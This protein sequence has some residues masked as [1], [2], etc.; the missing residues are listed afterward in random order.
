MARQ[1]DARRS[2][3]RRDRKARA[4]E[5]TGQDAGADKAARFALLA[6][7]VLGGAGVAFWHAGRDGGSDAQHPSSS[8]SPG[9]PSAESPDASDSDAPAPRFARSMACRE[10]HEKFY[11]LWAQ[12]HHGRAMQPFTP[13][14]AK[15]DLTPHAEAITVGKHRYRAD[16]SGAEAC[17]H[18]EGPDG[19][20]RYAIKHAM[21]GK[22]VYYFLTPLD[23]GRLQVLPIAYDVR[24]KNWY[25]V[26]ASM[27]RHIT[28]DRAVHWRDPLLTFN[29]S[30][31]GCHVSQLSTNY[32]LRDDTYY[33][34]WSEPGIN[35]ETCHGGGA[36][37]IRVCKAAPKGQPPKDLKILR[38]K[39]FNIEQ[40][41]ATCAGCHAK[42]RRISPAF[43][44]GEK[45]FDHYDLV[46]YESADYYPDGRDLGENYTLT[47][48]LRSPCVK[49][50]KLSCT[51]C[52]T[53]SGRYRFKGDKANGA[54]APCHQ[55]RV[56]NPKPHT[57][58]KPGTP[59]SRCI[60]CHMPKTRFAHM[61]RSDHSMLPPTPA[62][63]LA[64]KSPNACN[65]C[66]TKK[67]E[68]AAWADKLVRK[69]HQRDYQAPSLAIAGL[70]D[71]ARKNDW[72][73]LDE[74]LAYVISGGRDAVVTTSLV[75]L[76]VQCRDARKWPVLT[77][78]LDDPSP[79]VRGAVAGALADYFTPEA[80]QAL[81]KASGDE[82][83][84]VRIQAASALAAYPRDRL[85]AEDGG[86]LAAASAEF[87]R[88][89]CSRL[90]QWASH[91]NLGNY[92]AS[93]GR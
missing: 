72:K 87:E 27:V 26:T 70:L 25:N 65:L 23:R 76:L 46:T 63:T 58:H 62:A 88:S 20:K 83:R 93:R 48:W 41:N 6:V 73:R 1:E 4:E 82:C 42:A 29:T 59:G 91:Y 81:L 53:S 39:D 92:H 44:P 24:E 18:E 19:A 75:R 10:C 51:H 2:K 80:T 32:D 11:D 30:C 38:Y 71:A 90:D 60:E 34:V 36:E 33:T 16:I 37:H 56:G 49:S 54:C 67:E 78:A 85:G 57:R 50:G 43:A 64:F 15:T 77:K 68:D 17:V 3:Q 66:H 47:S 35:C 61:D 45:V 21:G 74:M 7:V 40:T 31:Y 69:W 86:R 52:H 89:L 8:S 55:K 84:L 13:Q 5:P 28:G 14:F 9:L 79:L 12:S 22:N